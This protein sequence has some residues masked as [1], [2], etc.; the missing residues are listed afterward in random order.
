MSEKVQEKSKVNL[1]VIKWVVAFIVPILIS[2]APTAAEGFTTD[3]RTYLVISIFAILTIAM[4][5]LPTFAI[6]ICLPVAYIV[7]L[8]IPNATAFG[9][10]AVEAPW[11][12][13][14]GFVLTIA[15]E[16]TG[17]LKRIAYSCILLFG[18]SFRGLLYGFYFLGFVISFVISDTAAKAILLGALG[19]GICNALD[20]KLGDRAAT[21]I[22]LACM[23]ASVGPSFLFL[24]GT[25]GTL[26]TFGAGEV[27]GLVLPTFMEYLYHMFLP[28]LIYTLLTVVIIDVIF[29]PKMNLGAKEYLTKERDA[30]GK[31]SCDEIKILVIVVA[32]LIGIITN[33][34]HGVAIGWLFTFAAVILCIPG[35][36]LIDADDFPKIKFS[37]IFFVV[38]CLVIGQVANAVGLGAWLS[39]F[40]QPL[41]EGSVTRMIGGVWFLAFGANFILTPL[42]IST[43][44]PATITEMA[45]ASGFNPVPIIYA[46]N[47]GME[48]L[49]FPYESGPA[50]AIFSYG[51]ISFKGF[52]KYN[53]LRAILSLVCFFVIYIPY[54]NLI[55]L[56]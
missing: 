11:L 16:K 53:L 56:I 38:G 18:G 19:L 42:A 9:G 12:I 50:L 44:F 41:I 45:L 48:Q 39:G 6:G 49:L 32:L 17:L 54:W 20:L 27:A 34:V 24:S 3:L 37:F 25:A 2:F 33:G 30:L 14:G 55:G 35:L 5:L 10:W 21:A 28:Q 43:A 1:T 23:A 52:F 22:G 13:L 7:F 4:G 36:K 15:M 47:Q 31:I 46:F 29:R 51:M 8:G 40:I 26:L